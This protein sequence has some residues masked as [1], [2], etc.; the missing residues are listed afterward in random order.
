MS[1]I[2]KVKKNF[3]ELEDSK[4]SDETQ[5]IITNL[6]ANSSLFTGIPVAASGISTLRDNFN[7]KRLANYYAG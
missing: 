7:G 6:T 1:A 5:V 3:S 4:L 2:I